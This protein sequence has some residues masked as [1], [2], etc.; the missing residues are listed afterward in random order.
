MKINEE[1][2]KFVIYRRKSSAGEDR[3]A[4]SLGSQK[5]ILSKYAKK[6]KLNIIA[7]FEEAHSAYKPGRPKFNEMMNMI[8]EGKANAIL[9]FKTSRLARN[10]IDGGKL[11]YLLTTGVISE[12][13]TLDQRHTKGS[14][15]EFLLAIDFAMDK[16]ASDD[17]SEFVKRD[18]TAKL[19]KGEYPGF[20]PLGYL[21]ID[22][23]GKISGKQYTFEKQGF[24][25]A[26]KRP[27]K[28][29]EKDPQMSELVLKL[30]ELYATGSY[31]LNR[32]RDVTNKWGLVGERS[33][34]K[35]SKQTIYRIL[36][37]PFYRGAI[38]WKGKIIEAYDI[39]DKYRKNLHEQ[40]V[41]KQLFDQ[42][43]N[44]LKN[45]NKP[46]GAPSYYPYTNYM[47]CGF[48]G[49]NISALTAKG[50][51]YYRCMKCKGV[52]YLPEKDLEAQILKEIDNLEIDEDFYNLA[53]REINLANEKEIKQRDLISKK[54]ET[55]LKRNQSKMDNLVRLKIDPANN[56]GDLLNDEEFIIQKK[57]IL[58]ERNLLKEQLEGNEE[59]VQQ[60]FNQCVDYVGFLFR[61]RDRYKKA[62]LEQK[63]EIF[64]FVCYNPVIKDKIL[65]TTAKNPN[66][67]VI[68]ENLRNSFT[69]TTKK[70]L[71]KT[72]TGLEYPELLLRRER[73]DSN[74]RPLA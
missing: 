36:S 42:V 10:P 46:M 18:I 30:F 54:Q 15:P 23:D 37:S 27:I 11:T 74:P 22:K 5:T 65:I 7:E 25:E 58:A 49:G 1:N 63:R 38:P 62:T 50:N 3:Q 35:L 73:R 33:K 71:G 51:V 52:P 40:I 2:L 14:N 13:R 70:P 43:Q 44:V 56:N 12:I 48:C 34:R 29:I 28:R 26:L 66:A 57:E 21:N 68:K 55:S 69:I 9:V 72:K 47:K 24:I 53:I 16:K 4:L 8:E 31:T 19:D 41:S 17:T 39:D 61:L 6:H 67:Y 32:L 64:R 59:N 45:I 60:W 20:S